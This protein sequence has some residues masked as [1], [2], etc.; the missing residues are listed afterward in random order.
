MDPGKLVMKWKDASRII[1]RI[2]ELSLARSTKGDAF[3]EDKPS[4]TQPQEE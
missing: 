2:I 3:R 1:D 4:V